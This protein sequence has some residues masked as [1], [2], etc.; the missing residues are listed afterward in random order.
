MYDKTGYMMREYYLT[1][2]E[3]YVVLRVGLFESEIIDEEIL[4]LPMN[5]EL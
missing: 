1:E 5:L 4:R 2:W 3:K